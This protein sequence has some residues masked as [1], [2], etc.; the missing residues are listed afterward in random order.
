MKQ[1]IH[2]GRING[3]ALT[4][5]QL[6]SVGACVSYFWQSLS[7]ITEQLLVGHQSGSQWTHSYQAASA[8]LG[9]RT[10][11]PKVSLWCL[12]M[13]QK[14]INTPPPEYSTSTKLLHYINKPCWI[15][16]REHNRQGKL[17]RLMYNPRVS[18]ILIS[19]QL[20]MQHNSH[21]I[22]TIYNNVFKLPSIFFR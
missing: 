17:Q 13:R 9:C 4:L 5:H 1:I 6:H 12:T 22:K 19:L 21:L 15:I 18:R 7:D 10:S 8:Q 14:K 3:G 2:G 20:I 16:K 11:P